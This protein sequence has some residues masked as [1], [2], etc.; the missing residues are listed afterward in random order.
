M[1]GL[2]TIAFFLKYFIL[3]FGK[4]K[5]VCYNYPK[6]CGG[7][8]KRKKIGLIFGILGG[9]LLVGLII[10]AVVST[11]FKE[12]DPERGVLQILY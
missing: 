6:I 4:N 9:L 5:K 11:I 2:K 7:F 10:F 12:S 8:M 1:E 3:I